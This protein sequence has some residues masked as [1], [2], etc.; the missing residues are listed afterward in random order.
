MTLGKKIAITI[1]DPSG[2]G[3]EVII[4]A[5]GLLD[6]D[7]SQ[8]VLVGSWHVFAQ[9]SEQLGIGLNNKIDIIDIPCDF[10][11]I[12][13]GTETTESGRLSYLALEKACELAKN[14]LIN[15]IVT[16][17]L[18]K[19]AINLAGYH[20]S[21]QTEI[22][23]KLLGTQERKKAEML[24]VADDF[25]V[26]LLTRHI[27]I[28][29]VPKAITVEKIIESAKIVVD[30][31]KHDFKIESPKLAIC[32]LNPHA[33]ESGLIGCEEQD[34][35]IP[36]IKELQRE[37]INIQGPF[38]ADTLFVK[39]AKPYVNK[40]KQPFDCYLACYHDQGLTPIKALAMDKTV[41]TTIGLP[42]IRTSPAHGTAFDIAGKNLANPASMVE[43]I[44]LALRL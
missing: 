22:L 23:Q 39:A 33:G 3:P 20:Y 41:N 10:S 40:T 11:N 43:A 7:F 36:A 15:A 8:I 1:G 5:L 27:S 44:K 35:I 29:D 12:K 26:L 4:K 9:T 17:P 24:F 32:G 31:L 34:V 19:N 2:I 18:S 37:N 38:P 30:S 25:R 14:N 28:L 6:V 21:G 16:A 42:V 13:C